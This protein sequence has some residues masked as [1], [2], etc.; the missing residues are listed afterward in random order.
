MKKIVFCIVLCS[1]IIACK[2]DDTG[3]T[4]NTPLSTSDSLI[5]ID[6]NPDF[7]QL[8]G[9][10]EVDGSLN[11]LTFSFV[12]QS[13]PGAVNLDEDTGEMRVADPAIFDFE[14]N[15]E[16][17]AVVK[18]SDGN[19]SVESNV[20]INIIDLYYEN[21]QRIKNIHTTSG[22]GYLSTDTDINI[23]IS[24]YIMERINYDVYSQAWTVS[25]QHD[26]E[27]INQ[28]RFWY[29]SVGYSF[30][31]TYNITYDSNNRII[32]LEHNFEDDEF[33]TYIENYSITY[34]AGR[35]DV[36]NESTTEVTSIYFD[37]DG[38]LSRYENNSKSMDYL[39]DGNG[40]LISK[41]DQSGY[42][43][44]FTYD[45]K[46]N[47]FPDIVSLNWLDV[48]HIIF[49][50]HFEFNEPFHFESRNCGLWTSKNNILEVLNSQSSNPVMSYTYTYDSNGY[51]ISKTISCGNESFEYKYIQ[52]P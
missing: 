26:G 14:I 40:N 7:D 11:N 1:L 34:I 8:I 45:T 39:Y 22:C 31:S 28:Y 5:S 23:N 30:S 29:G 51:P 48:D 27:L 46:R 50:Q 13:H 4:L 9:S 35:I 21:T 20:S 12:Q 3:E 19:T 44:L 32:A 17:T 15:E 16:I 33:N 6:E 2:S 42:Q 49:S 25:L 10:I 37:N 38:R 43:I 41:T 24:N 18:I 36:L 52:E 47:P